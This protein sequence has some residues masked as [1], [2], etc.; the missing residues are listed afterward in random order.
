MFGAMKRYVLIMGLMLGLAAL[1]PR[2][3]DS[4]AGL[5]EK[6]QWEE[7][8]NTMNARIERLEE[9]IQLYQQRLNKVTS[10]IH[11]LREDLARVNN[12]GVNSATQKSLELLADAIKE[13]D[14]KRIADGE[15]VVNALTEL[16]KG[17]L[18]RPPAGRA[19]AAP[20]S[21]PTPDKDGYDYTVQSG[22]NPSVIAS[23]LR[24]NG[25]KVT[26]QQI[27][28]ANPGVNWTKLKINQKVF[29]PAPSP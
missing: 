1:S 5:A 13:V 23:K 19:A 10:E 16:H 26:A 12:S 25:V 6:Q 2:A 14:R 22:D 7:R 3:Q 18:N 17:L 11:A 4:L 21:K 8:F 29:I 20:A 27:I 28:E 15:K 9:A 24:K